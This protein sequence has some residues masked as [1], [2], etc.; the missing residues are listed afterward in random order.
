MAARRAFRLSEL[1]VSQF[2]QPGK[3]V[4]S[5]MPYISFS[6]SK[7]N[8]GNFSRGIG[9]RL[10]KVDLFVHAEQL[11]TESASPVKTYG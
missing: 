3:P 8:V 7:Q 9:A 1:G 5:N 4:S 11:T 6:S 2:E 10:V